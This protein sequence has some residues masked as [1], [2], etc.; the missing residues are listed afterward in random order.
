M[1]DLPGPGLKLVSPALA[2][3][4]LT[5]APPGKSLYLILLTFLFYMGLPIWLKEIETLKSCCFETDASVLFYDCH[6]FQRTTINT[7]VLLLDRNSLR[8]YCLHAFI[9]P[10]AGS[11]APLSCTLLWIVLSWRELSCPRLCPFLFAQPGW[12]MMTWVPK[13]AIPAPELLVGSAKV[14]VS[15]VSQFNFSL[16][17]VQLLPL[18]YRCC[19]WE[20]PAPPKNYTE[21][22]VSQGD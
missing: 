8:Y 22:S 4:F 6:P 11:V 10:G 14:S 20:Q 7:V 16:C 3:G 2:G 18:L 17:S 21:I 13:K 9:P 12:Y 19:S 15:I 5:T 1:W